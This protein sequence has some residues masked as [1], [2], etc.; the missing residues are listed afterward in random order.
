[1]QILPFNTPDLP[2]LPSLQPSDWGDLVPRFQ[3]FIQSSFCDP[4]KITID[5]QIVGIGTTM[6]HADTAWLACIVVHPEYR[7]MGLGR[8]ITTALIDRIDRDTFQTIYLDAT[9]YGFPLYQKLG[10]E[11]EAEY[12]HLKIENP[13]P[14]ST[15]PNEIVPFNPEHLERIYQLDFE[16][17]GEDRRGILNDFVNQSLVYIKDKRISGYYIPGWGDFPIVA[18]NAEAGDALLAFRT[19][20]IERAILPSANTQAIDQLKSIGFEKYKVSRRMRL[21][22]ERQWNPLFVYNRV[23]GQLG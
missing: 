19:Q 1:M 9:V 21:G 12:S 11:L 16:A 20:Q 4:L 10:F 2:S 23:S 18:E 7:S 17:Y 8:S 3:Y 13:L 5:N 6:L 15:L 14:D 22:P